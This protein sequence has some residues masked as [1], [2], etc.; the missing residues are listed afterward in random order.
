MPTSELSAPTGHSARAVPP[1]PAGGE[2]PDLEFSKKYRH[3]HALEYFWK[4]ERGFSRRFSTVLERHMARRAL[5]RAGHPRTVLDLP[6]GSGRFWPVLAER[7]DRVIYAADLN[8]PMINVGRQMRPPALVAR[9]QTFEASAFAVPRPDDFVECVFSMR[10]MH[11]IEEPE[12]RVRMLREFAR[13][14]SQTVLVSLWVDGNYQAWRRRVRDQRLPRPAVPGC[15]NRLVLPRGVFEEEIAEA[16][17][18]V[19]DRVDF[20]PLYSMWSTYVLAVK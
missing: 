16:G 13:L 10:L 4:H 2:V 12:H 19:V 5:A 17:L 11:H 15:R 20:L 6:C 9:V 7:G 1:P 18:R 14:A 3:E 8:Q